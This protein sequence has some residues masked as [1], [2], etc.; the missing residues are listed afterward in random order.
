[1]HLLYLTFH[2]NKMDYNVYSNFTRNNSVLLFPCKNSARTPPQI[3]SARPVK[4]K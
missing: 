3:F 1:M 2:M 4:N